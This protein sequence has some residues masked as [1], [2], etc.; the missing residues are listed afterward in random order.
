MCLLMSLMMMCTDYAE[1]EE[2]RE[3]LFHSTV[4]MGYSN[5]TIAST[6]KIQHMLM[7]R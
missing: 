6:C 3:M 2:I 5:V 4:L 7:L 1:N